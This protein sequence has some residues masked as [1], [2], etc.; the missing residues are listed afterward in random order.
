MNAYGTTETP[1]SRLTG[2]SSVR[3]LD[4]GLEALPYQQAAASTTQQAAIAD[5]LTSTGALWFLALNN[6]TAKS[7]H[8]ASPADQSNAIHRIQLDSYQPFSLALCFGTVIQGVTDKYPVAFPY[9]ASA[10]QPV[11]IN[12][13]VT[14]PD[15][16][17][18]AIVHPSL[19][20]QHILDTPGPTSDYRLK[21]VE[22]PQPI[23]NGSTIGAVILPPQSES[24][25]PQE[26]FFCNLAAGWGTAA[27]QMQT[28]AGGT[29]DVSSQTLF[30]GKPIEKDKSSL[31]KY[32]SDPAGQVL[33]DDFVFE[34]P[35]YPQRPIS[36][37]SEW[38][39]FLNPSIPNSNTSVFNVLM[40]E[41]LWPLSSAQV[42]L[43]AMM[44]NGLAR[45]SFTSELQGSVT[46]STGR[47][48]SADLDG[49]FWVSGKGD[50][51]VVNP[52]ES[53]DWVKLRVDSYLEG[54]AYNTI[55]VS[56]RIAIGILMVY[57]LL[58]TGHVFYAGITGTNQFHI[59]SA[60][61]LLNPLSP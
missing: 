30:N 37:A 54:Y 1:T 61:L 19:T 33:T 52:D 42:V 10:N 26:V 8:G 32:P 36:V 22:L 49:N 6:V 28:L 12:A 16:Y 17:F 14:S 4:I 35:S 60:I 40:H 13:N 38:T 15:S 31:G 5:A 20:R 46:T 53:K 3:Q 51:F 34:Y 45:T 23:F 25:V 58:A 48:G 43:A 2:K 57:C 18:D 41:K 55:N 50:V 29:G 47:N 44:A 56:S 21:W 11:F 27:L 9:I 7:G 39:E 59:L 24:E